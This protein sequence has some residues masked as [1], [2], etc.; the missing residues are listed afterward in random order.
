M[1]LVDCYMKGANML[2]LYRE[3]VLTHVISGALDI[4]CP[5]YGAGDEHDVAVGYLFGRQLKTELDG[6]VGIGTFW[7]LEHDFLSALHE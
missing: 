1:S 7:M 6:T 4:E 5:R 2:G 3:G